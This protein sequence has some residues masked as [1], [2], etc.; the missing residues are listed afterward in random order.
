MEWVHR[1]ARKSE[2][3]P[4]CAGQIMGCTYDVLLQREGNEKGRYRTGR[5]AEG[6]DANTLFQDYFSD[7]FKYN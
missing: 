3:Y 7:A 5:V 4:G 6:Y 2:R 1:A